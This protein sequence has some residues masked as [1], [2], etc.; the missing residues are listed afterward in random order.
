[1]ASDQYEELE[2]Q[3]KRPFNYGYLKRMLAYGRPY[4]RQLSGVI[5]VMVISTMLTLSEPYMLQLMVDEGIAKSNLRLV[6]TLALLWLAFQGIS[7]IAEYVRIRILNRTGQH[8]LYDLRQELFNHLQWL[9]LRFYDGR[10][11]GRIMAR[12]TNDVEAINELINT[13]LVTI[14]S[15]SVSLIGIIV[16]MFL[17]NPRLALLSFM[18]MPGLIWVVARLRPAMETAWRNERRANSNINANLNE[19]ITGIRVSQ[20]FCREKENTRLFDRLNDTYLARHMHAIKVEIV[21]WPLVDVF[22]MLGTCAVL[23]YGA[24]L[25]MQDALTVG[26]ILSFSSYLWR[27]WEPISAISRIYSRVLSAMASG[28]RI[29]EYLDTAPEVPDSP[30]AAPLDVLHG[31]VSFRDVS[32]RYSDGDKYVLQNISFDVEPGQ[33]VA[34]VGPTGAGKTSVINLLMRFYDPQE[35]CVM[36]D[37]HDLRDVTMDSLR[38]QMALVLQD[39]YLF[40]GTIADNIRYSRLD[41]TMEDIVRVAQAVEVDHFVG[42]FEKGY[43]HE[44]NERGTRLSVGQRQLICFAR[45]LLAD[46]RIL[47]LDEATSSVDSQTEAAIQKAMATLLAGRTSFVIAHRL[48]TIRRA[49]RIFV[50]DD[51]RIVEQ[52]THAEL[53][54]ADGHYAHLYQRQFAAWSEDAPAALPA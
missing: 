33:L 47:I 31:R 52:G 12:V 24:W 40:S 13:G 14:V 7:A 25:V 11:V 51:G 49:D 19:S 30:N 26:Y 16:V 39:S 38:S 4:R 44:V 8:I 10:P 1:M 42:R 37:G 17:L 48:S 23:W 18:I 35:G 43:E 29:F 50:I 5:A 27:F 54:E 22:G 53:L 3:D 15:Q 41:A 20:A 32:F 45:A 2:E 28:E 21:V 34:L 46:P 6:T 9:S 36:V